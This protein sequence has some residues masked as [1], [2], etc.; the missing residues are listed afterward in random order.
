MKHL[1]KSEYAEAALTLVC[2]LLVGT[3]LIA[4]ACAARAMSD[5]PQPSPVP[6]ALEE[7]SAPAMV[8][9]RA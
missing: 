1:V 9:A 5:G 3:I 8:G 7:A 6:H 2:A 4:F